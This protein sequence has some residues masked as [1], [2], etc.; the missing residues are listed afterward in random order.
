MK[1]FGATLV[2]MAELGMLVGLAWWGF[3]VVGGTAAWV[4]AVA[5][6]SVAVTL[7][8]AFLAPRAPKPLRPTVLAMFVRLDML[9]LGA[10]AAYFTDAK[11]LGVATAAAAVV[12]TLLAGGTTPPAP[13]PP[14]AAPSVPQEIIE[15]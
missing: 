15:P 10:A 12:G 5:A 2:F 1:W 9:L 8:G 4:L 11:I 13:N 3:H 14:A 6:P 7:W